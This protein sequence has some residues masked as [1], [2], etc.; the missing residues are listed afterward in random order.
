MPIRAYLRRGGIAR[1]WI[2]KPIIILCGE[3]ADTHS[4]IRGT[5]GRSAV[6]AIVGRRSAEKGGG[7]NDDDVLF[8]CIIVQVRDEHLLPGQ[9]Y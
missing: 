1:G 8:W 7:M 4:P 9:I 2:P 3:G 5:W 6:R